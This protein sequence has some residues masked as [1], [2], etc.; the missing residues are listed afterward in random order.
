[1]MKKFLIIILVCLYACTEHDGYTIEGEIDNANG[2]K[3]LLMKVSPDGEHVRIDSCIVKRGKFE[4]RGWLDFPEYCI[5]YAGDNGPL[6]LFV[7]NVKMTVKLN[8]TEMQNS[9]VYGSKENE[10]FVEY[11]NQMTDFDDDIKQIND[12]YV[13]SQIET[14]EAEEIEETVDFVEKLNTLRINRIEYLKSF[15]SK[16][17]GQIV[18]A[19]M[20]N[21]N[22]GQYTA[23]E[24]LELFVNQYDERTTNSTWVKKLTERVDI[25]KRIEIGQ[26]FIDI[27]LSDTDD[28]ELSISDFVGKDNYVLI[29]FWASW[30]APCRV[31]NP[32]MVKIYN[33]F[34]NKGFEII[35]ISFDRDKTE[36]T[37][38]IEADKLS[39]RHV[40]DT[41]GFKGDAARLYA[42]NLIRNTVLL[43]PQGVI[44][45]RGLRGDA[46]E[47]KLSAIFDDT[48][49]KD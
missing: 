19:M 5:L 27:K 13:A 32:T 26:T 37:E 30:C 10:L 11:N 20:V 21:N 39:W 24:E 16:N 46:L 48:K 8:L 28:N 9:E 17:A 47:E 31:A 23:V 18:A 43:D 22:L 29:D 44:I 4:M 41:D 42:I 3:L 36:W 35:G 49:N 33:K 40:I 2:M 45:A 6:P 14:E 1:M 25:L 15:I 12:A 34:K 7:E 38:A